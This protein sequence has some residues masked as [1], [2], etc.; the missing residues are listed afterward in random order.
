MAG[1]LV[2]TAV[3]GLLCGCVGG[4][5]GGRVSCRSCSA[6]RRA[7]PSR[8]STPSSSATH[9]TPTGAGS[10]ARFET[11]FQLAWVIG[12]FLP[13][14]IPVPDRGRL[15]AHRRHGGRRGVHL[16]PGSGSAACAQGTYEWDPVSRK[17]IRYGLRRVD[18]VVGWARGE[19]PGHTARQP[20]ERT[21]GR[22]GAGPAAPTAPV[23][24]RGRH[25]AAPRATTPAA[26]AT[27]AADAG[28]PPPGFVAHPLGAATRPRSKP[29][30]GRRVDA[31]DPAPGVPGGRRRDDADDTLFAEPRWREPG[32]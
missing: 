18:A 14:V 26:G 29:G 21:T 7:P 12:A 13:V 28:E 8:P 3:G 19:P 15:P 24:A 22:R 1:S 32:S 11:R 5:I 6:P 16:L 9:P 27:G 25:P 30:S 31:A 20:T 2:V 23:T 10:F 17:L 4:L